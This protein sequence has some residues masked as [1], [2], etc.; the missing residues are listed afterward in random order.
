VFYRTDFL[1]FDTKIELK[2]DGWSAFYIV[3]PLKNLKRVHT[4][5]TH[6]PKLL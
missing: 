6:I 2:T 1:H 5:Y 4:Q 3:V